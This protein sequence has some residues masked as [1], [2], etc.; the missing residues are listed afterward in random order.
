VS[1][2]PESL[3]GKL[4]AGE[5]DALQFHVA[6][7][8]GLADV[9]AG[10]YKRGTAVLAGEYEP[11][12]TTPAVRAAQLR[13]LETLAE[14]LPEAERR[15]LDLTRLAGTLSADDLAA[16]EF[17]LAVG[18]RLPDV[19]RERYDLG[20]RILSGE[21]QAGTGEAV[22][23]EARRLARLQEQ[24]PARARGDVELPALAGKLTPEQSDALEY[25]LTIRFRLKPAGER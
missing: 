2:R 6:V 19:S 12:T 23:A 4:T 11:V 21:H 5:M 15:K 16:L 7:R 14:L 8:Y 13:R 3:A 24:L 10:L 25:Y 22:S 20:A 18:H 1:V 17:A 9:A